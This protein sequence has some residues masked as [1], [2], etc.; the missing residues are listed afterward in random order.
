MSE[1]HKPRP[2]P[3]LIRWTDTVDEDR[4]YLSV[5]TIGELR[6]G[7]ERMPPGRRRDRLNRWLDDELP[8]RFERRIL[9]VDIET[10]DVWGRMMARTKKVGRCIDA[11]DGFIA[12]TAEVHGLEV[13]TRNVPHFES[14]GVKICNPWSG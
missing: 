4:T 2:D 12:A 11:V 13:I 10:G 1:W 9:P 5:V 7:M 3:G 6:E 14:T 8:V